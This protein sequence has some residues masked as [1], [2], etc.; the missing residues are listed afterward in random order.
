MLKINLRNSLKALAGVAVL[1]MS[2]NASAGAYNF[3]VVDNPDN[4][5]F[6]GAP[7]GFM[8]SQSSNT[9]A[10]NFGAMGSGY[11]SAIYIESGF[12]QYLNDTP[13]FA[14]TIGGDQSG[15]QTAF[16]GQNVAL[17]GPSTMLHPAWNGSITTSIIAGT[18]LDT[19]RFEIRFD[20]DN[21]SL[22]D[23]ENLIGNEGFRI[24]AVYN[25][26]QSSALLGT[27]GMSVK[28]NA[29]AVPTPSAFLAGMGLIGIAAAR[30]RRSAA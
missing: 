10:F 11:I 23:L 5:A 19:E 20:L 3:S 22:Q 12:D 16:S 14:G 30:R 4:I 24:A 7:G 21:G 18:G 26:G 25:D 15:S 28:G 6:S 17:P 29:K 2:A 8:V 27:A 9:V 1:G 13:T